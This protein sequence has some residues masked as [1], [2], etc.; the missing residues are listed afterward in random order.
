MAHRFR[1]PD[2][3]PS[4]PLD[5]RGPSHANRVTVHV[6]P[7]RISFEAST[8]HTLLDSLERQG[9]RWPSSC[10]AGTCRTCLCTAPSGAVK[11]D[12][13]WPGLTPEEKAEGCVLPCVA[14]PLTD[15]V[16][17]DPLAS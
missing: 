14:Y 8:Q 11:Y 15:V 5:T 6:Q 13:A 17:Q 1:G 12:M 2:L 4:T 16:L 9:L 10:R 3:K 7:H